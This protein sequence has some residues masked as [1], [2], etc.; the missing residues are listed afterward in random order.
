MPK[1]IRWGG[2]LAYV[3]AMFAGV[4]VLSQGLVGAWQGTL[5]SGQLPR[6][7]LKIS[8]A[9]DGSLRGVMYRPDR[10]AASI[11]LSAVKFDEGSVRIE[12]VLVDAAFA[13]KLAADGK[14]LSGSWTE[15]KSTSPVVFVLATPDTSWLQSGTAPMATTADPAFEVASI[16]PSSPDES[17]RSFGLRSHRFTAKYS[18]V[19]DLMKWAYGIRDRQIEGA[20]G[21]MDEEH[22]DIIAEA[23]TPGQ[24][25]EDQDRLMMR[26][27][28]AERF[29]LTAHS[30]HKDFPVYA[31]QVGDRA[32]KLKMSDSSVNDHGRIFM[33]PATDGEMMEQF[34]YE[35]MPEFE[36]ILMNFIPDRQIVD[37]TKLTGRYDFTLHVPQEAL[38]SNDQNE[39]ATAMIDAVKGI[40]MRLQP[41]H[42]ALEVFVIDRVEK[43]SPN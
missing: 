3:L 26:K 38:Q 43:P 20:P 4:P 16:R 18:T 6:I 24:P 42:A 30:I 7:V 8:K 35:S 41:K 5:P 23:D 21:W 2:W 19:A 36:K 12:S 31:L 37:E 28:L 1:S 13:G 29:G 9:E 25:S 11:P 39:R 10:N 15:N 14:S 22:Y 17:Q 34:S 27:L 33:Q 32:P 40:G